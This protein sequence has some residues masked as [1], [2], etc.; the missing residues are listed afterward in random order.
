MNTEKLITDSEVVN[1][2]IESL[3]DIPQDSSAKYALWVIGLDEEND[4]MYD[5]F[6]YEFDTPEEAV[7]K[8][9]CINLKFIEEQTEQPILFFCD[10]NNIDHFSIEVE[11]VV[12]DPDE[13]GSTMNIGTIYRRELCLEED[14]GDLGLGDY[15]NVVCITKKD[16]ELLEDGTLKVSCK[17]LRDFNKNDY[18]LFEF[19]DEANPVVLEYKIISKVIYTD[20]DYYHCELNI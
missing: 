19:V 5:L 14:F 4:P 16:F 1:S 8:A 15:S 10:N 6:I 3:G 17:L 18:V 7:N 11:T 2:V 9:E 20:G 12:P 13:E